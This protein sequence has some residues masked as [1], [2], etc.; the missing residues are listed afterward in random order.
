MDTNE[1]KYTKLVEYIR[2]GLCEQTHYGILLYLNKNKV[3]FKAGNDNGY[4]FFHRSCMKPLQAASLIDLNLDEKY[5]LSLDEIALCCASHTGEEEHQQKV[6]SVLKKI[7]L[8]QDDLLCKAI[9]PLSKDEQKRLIINNLPLNKIHNNCS[10]KHA[11]MLA[12]CEHL[13][14][15]KSCYKDINHPLSDLIIKKVCE[16][17]ETNINDVII[18]KDGCGLP[19]IATTLEELGKGFLNL[20]TNKKYRKIKEAFLQYPY[21]IGGKNRLDSEIINAGENLIAKVGACG[22]C[23]VVN[24]RTEECLVVKI[25][26]SNME[27][28][29]FAV[30]DALKQLKWLDPDT[31]NSSRVKDIYIKEILSQDNEHLGFVHSCFCIN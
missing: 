2:N 5:N 9:T 14:F 23:T 16:L 1:C 24:L 31:I 10:G 7:G 19:V 20:F 6:L 3:L 22:L 18:S 30:I 21:L 12:I 17:C 4:K 27:A 13:N 8:S 15:D 11:A 25:A 26:D 29:S 28:R